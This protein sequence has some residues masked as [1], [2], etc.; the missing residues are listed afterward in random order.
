MRYF[1]EKIPN[2]DCVSFGPS[3]SGIH[4]TEETLSISST[5]RMWKIFTESSGKYKITGL[6]RLL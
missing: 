3:M 6:A 2:L 1:Y 4:T 5:E